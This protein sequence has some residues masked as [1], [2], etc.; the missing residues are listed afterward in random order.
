MSPGTVDGGGSAVS[1]DVLLLHLTNWYP[2]EKLESDVFAPIG[3]AYVAAALRASG[4]DVAVEIHRYSGR[5]GVADVLAR[6]EP[7]IIGISATGNEIAILKHLS[8]SLRNERPSIPQIAGG[9]CCLAGESLFEGSALDAVVIGEGE[10]P[11]LDLVDRFRGQVPISDV[12]GILVRLPDGAI[13]STPPRPVPADLDTLPIPTYEHIP[14]A[15]RVLRV[16]SSRGCPYSCT[17]CEIKDFY[18]SKKIRYHGADYM[19]RVIQGLL[20]RA[21]NSVRHLYFN[22]DEFLLSADHLRSMATV[23]RSFG[24]TMVFQTRVQDVLRH[25]DVLAEHVDVIHEIHMGVESFSPTQLERWEKRASV[26]QNRQATEVL[27]G[28]GISYYPYMILSDSVT[29]VEELRDTCQGLLDLPPC[30]FTV[31]DEGSPV[32]PVLSPLHRGLHLNRL[33]NFTGEIERSQDTEYLETVWDFLAA[34]AEEYE[35]LTELY[36]SGLARAALCSEGAESLRDE[37]HPLARLIDRRI[38]SIPALAE[39]R[40]RTGDAAATTAAAAAFGEEARRTR[41]AFLM[42]QLLPATAGR[43]GGPPS[44]NDEVAL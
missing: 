23:T 28:L 2:Q 18:S 30:P 16:Y 24:L 40:L 42:G 36:V 15:S 17:F 32:R 3:S 8:L 41:A 4:Y 9:Y 1:V 25:R 7:K 5:G 10:Q 19:T 43:G 27:A 35:K 12:L 20:H 29:T 26:E 34:T 13:V 6:Y 31:W 14:A 37:L 38:A 22:D 21:G 33:K 44:R 39:E 11:M